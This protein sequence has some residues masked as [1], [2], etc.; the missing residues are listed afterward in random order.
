MGIGAV[1]H[2]IKEISA[3]ALRIGGIVV[4]PFF[5]EGATTVG[6]RRFALVTGETQYLTIVIAH[7]WVFG[8]L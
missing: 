4:N 8:R 2:R 1:Y 3:L 6:S 5:A 7:L